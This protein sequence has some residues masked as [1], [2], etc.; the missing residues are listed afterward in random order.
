MKK[1]LN[2]AGKVFKYAGIVI[3]IL[4]LTLLFDLIIYGVVK[5]CPACGNFWQFVETEGALSFPIVAGITQ[6]I[7][8]TLVSFRKFRK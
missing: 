2:Y 4:P 8:Q 6:W 7:E 3:L 1:V 5:S